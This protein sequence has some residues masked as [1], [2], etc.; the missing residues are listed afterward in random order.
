MTKRILAVLAIALLVGCD[1]DSGATAPVTDNDGGF[2]PADGLPGDGPSDDTTTG[3]AADDTGGGAVD[4]GGGAVDTGGGK[5]D[6]GGGDTGSTTS[7]KCGAFTCA[8]GTQECCVTAGIGACVAKGGIC[9]GA[10]YGC[11]S[12]A[13]CGTGQVC[14]ISGA[15]GTGGA[16]CTAD[17]PS[18]T[19]CN[20]KADCKGGKDCI[21]IGSGIKACG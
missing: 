17:C 5:V 4:T 13:N 3:D 14:C 1:D 18:T 21:D 7:M 10:R 8:V 9:A 16:S 15:G 19:T 2:Q 11:T 12:A 6:T 20:T